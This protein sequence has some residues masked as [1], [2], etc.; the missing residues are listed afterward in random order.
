VVCA[1]LRRR[2]F[3]LCGSGRISPPGDILLDADSKHETA[4]QIKAIAY[5]HALTP[6]Q[7]A[8]DAKALM[9]FL[10]A[11]LSVSAGPKGIVGHCMGGYFAPQL[12]GMY[13]DKIKA[14]A[15]INPVKLLNDAADNPRQFLDKVQ[16]ELYFGFAELDQGTPPELI[17]SWTEILAKT[18][19]AKWTVET[20]AGQR[21]GFAVPGRPTIWNQ[22][23]AEVVFQ[24]TFDLFNRQ[25]R[26]GDPAS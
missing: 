11:D 16:G 1:P 4:L 23:A 3:L 10:D 6:F 7:V 18:C 19:T 17:E 2:R 20:H 26:E 25:L 15:S 5:A 8:E 9:S 12:A 13:P 21:H 14:A 24:R 22:A